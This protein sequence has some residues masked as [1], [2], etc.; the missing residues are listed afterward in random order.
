[1]L[2]KNHFDTTIQDGVQNGRLVFAAQ[3]GFVVFKLFFGARRTESIVLE[4]E[5]IAHRF[6]RPADSGAHGCREDTKQPY[7]AKF[8]ELAGPLGYGVPF[9]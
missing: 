8:G 9:L 3:I 7:R 6:R 4:W 1:M 5:R 2:K